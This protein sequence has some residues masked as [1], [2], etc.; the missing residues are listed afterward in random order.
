MKIKYNLTEDDYVNFN[1]YHL[2]NSSSLKR[3]IMINRFL[4]PLIFL[5]MPFVLGNISNISFGY[6][7]VI[8]VLTYILWVVLYEKNLYK[9]NKKRIIKMLKENSNEGLLGEKT[10]EVDEK[11]IKS[12][13][14]SGESTIYIK[15]IKNIVED[16]EYIFVY[17]NSVEAIVIPL[18]AFSNNED[19]EKFKALLN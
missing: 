2:K 1:I 11:Q 13:D 17:T 3:S 4:T 12:I 15:T 6:W 5:V 8:F 9:I 18:R 16:K 19:K 7:A 14:K 10:L